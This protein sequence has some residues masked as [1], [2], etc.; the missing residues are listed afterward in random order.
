MDKNFE[1]ADIIVAFIKNE[2]TPRQISV[3]DDWINESEANKRLF[4]SLLDEVAFEQRL[5]RSRVL[6]LE[7][8]FGKVRARVRK[9]KRGYW[10][11]VAVAASVAVVVAIGG[12]MAYWVGIP[13]K[14]GIVTR[15]QSIS[16]GKS[17]AFLTLGTG[18]KVALESQ[19]TL[20]RGKAMNIRIQENG[21]VFY[22]M[23]DS[24][25]PAEV[26]Y[27]IMETPRGAEF[28][29]VLSDGTKVWLNAGTKLRYPVKFIGKERRVELTGE[30]YFDVTR[31]E[32]VPFVV[33]TSRSAVTVLGTEF[34]VRDYAGEA[35]LTTL[36]QGSVS[37]EDQRGNAYLIRPGQQVNIGKEGSRVLDV[38]TIYFTSWKD[39]YFIFN[40]ATLSEIMSELS[41]WYDFDCF[42]LNPDAGNERLTARLKK[43]DDI[44]VILDILSRTGNIQFTQKGR[45]ITVRSAW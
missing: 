8:A 19:D 20:L 10:R 21:E 25:A 6:E 43:Y 37:V 4:I 34:C 23:A 31:D 27:N 9:S 39:G 15:Q 7:D 5:D 41:K 32:D 29:L 28:Q 40:E 14:Q 33:E 13:E 3:L 2:A 42:F 35:N 44:S 36:V 26:E 24:I 30:A 12:I 45:A 18:E 16:V 22:E 11:Y 17:R 1:I 38:E